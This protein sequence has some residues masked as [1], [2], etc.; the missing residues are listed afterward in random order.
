MGT[1]FRAE[2]V[3]PHCGAVHPA[4][5]RICPATGQRLQPLAR[6]LPHWLGGNRFWLALGG[7]G[8][9]LILSGLALALFG[10][11]PAPVAAVVN[12]TPAATSTDAMPVASTQS[13]SSSPT[14]TQ[15][16]PTATLLPT[17]TP[18]PPTE[19]ALTPTVALPSAW[20]A[21]AGALPSQLVTGLKAYVSFDPPLANRVR[22][23]PGRQARI[24]GQIQPGTVV[25]ILEGPNCANNWVWWRVQSNEGLAGWTAE[26]DANT[27]W[28]LPCRTQGDSECY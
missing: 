5:A 18:S 12:Q 9:L 7:L 17:E 16:Q 4:E 13:V 10:Q 1:A 11:R 25:T 15:V 26:G 27:Y 2:S 14:A 21:C 19:P 6:G 23:L 20:S 22:E 3:C 28:L 8:V 24:L